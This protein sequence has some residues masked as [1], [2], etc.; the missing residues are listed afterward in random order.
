M[1]APRRCLEGIFWVLW[2]GAP[3]AGHGGIDDEPAVL[4][5]LEED[6]V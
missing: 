2:T 1:T 3:V 4:R 6:S 5:V